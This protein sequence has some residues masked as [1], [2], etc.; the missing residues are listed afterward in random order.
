MLT[1]ESGI[2]LK[3]NP[4][5]RYLYHYEHMECHGGAP[6]LYTVNLTLS[7][8]MLHICGVSKMFGEGSRKQKKT[9]DTKTLT[10]LTYKLIA[11]LH[12]TRCQ[13][14]VVKDGDYFEGQ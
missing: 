10:L 7:Q 5:Q 13:P 3:G 6:S 4:S 12:N 1:G 14:C 2:I 11:I 8:L 9:E